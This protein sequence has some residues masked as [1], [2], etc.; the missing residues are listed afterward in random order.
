MGLIMYLVKVSSPGW[1]K[2]VGSK[3]EAYFELEKHICDMCLDWFYIE[4][5]EYPQDVY[6]LLCTACGCEFILEE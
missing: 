5:K 1:E 3:L 2:E 4:Y 6:D